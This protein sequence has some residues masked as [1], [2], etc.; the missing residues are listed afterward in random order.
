MS[1]PS[2]GHDFPVD[3]PVP[4]VGLDEPAEPIL[5]AQGGEIPKGVYTQPV[6]TSGLDEPA[7]ADPS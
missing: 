4:P 7:P 3:A 5:N 6:E 1:K 2:Y